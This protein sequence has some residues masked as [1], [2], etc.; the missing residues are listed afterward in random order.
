MKVEMLIKLESRGTTMEEKIYKTFDGM[1]EGWMGMFPDSN[2]NEFFIWFI[3]G[4]IAVTFLLL[5][6]I[7][8]AKR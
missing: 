6:K 8:E 1:A 7:G 4:M 3:I 5:C 2:V